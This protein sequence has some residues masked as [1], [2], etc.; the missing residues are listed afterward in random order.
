MGVS[1]LE[2]RRVAPLTWRSAALLFVQGTIYVG[3]QAAN[4]VQIAQHNVIGAVFFGFLISWL[5]GWNV[6]GVAFRNGWGG[7]VYALGAAL[8]TGIGMLLGRGV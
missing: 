7:I 5:W 6:K 1:D 4:F 3:L 8:G 2:A